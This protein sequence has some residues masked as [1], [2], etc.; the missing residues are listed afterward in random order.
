MTPPKDA[1]QYDRTVPVR[2]NALFSRIPPEVL[3]LVVM[4]LSAVSLEAEQ[5]TFSEGDAPDYCYLVESGAVRITKLGPEGES[6]LLAV[7]HPG[8]FFGELALYDA[9]PR[10]ATAKAA[11]PT[12]LSRLDRSAFERLCRAAPLEM[13]ST[14]AEASIARVRETNELLVRGLADAGRLKAV[15]ANLGTLSHNLRSPLGTIRNAA[16]MLSEW[17]EDGTL[18]LARMAA[19]VRIIQNT[20]D[21]A[22]TQIDHLMAR[23]RGEVGAERTHIQVGELLRDLRE[24][25][26]GLLRGAVRYEDQQIDYNGCVLVDRGEWV[27]ALANLV[28]N[29]IEALPPGGGEVKVT[30]CERD[31]EVIFAVEDDGRGVS[32]EKLP[33]FFDRGF[34]D[35]KAGGTGFGTAHVRAVAESHGGRV[36]VR[37]EVGTGTVVEMRLAPSSEEKDAPDPVS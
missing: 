20:A 30:V 2:E 17:L 7:A 21:R 1:Q 26:S 12:R 36:D 8:D 34:T 18:D 19:F 22:L 4:S 28:K 6:E 25:V 37:S 5:A 3:D 33:R 16:D 9:A 10:S 27:G 31:G 29:S 15:G 14:L 23:L 11:V 35:G 32:P 24:Q 13:A